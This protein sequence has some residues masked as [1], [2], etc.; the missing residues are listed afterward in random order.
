MLGKLFT[1][2]KRF[3]QLTNQ[4]KRY[5]DL[6]EYQSKEIMRKYGVRVQNGDV[7]TTAEQAK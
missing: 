1:N 6:H 4:T 5:F 3:T 7:A 2:G